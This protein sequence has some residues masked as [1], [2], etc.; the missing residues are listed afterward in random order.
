L[1]G[2]NN[3]KDIGPCCYRNQISSTSNLSFLSA[4]TTEGR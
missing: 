1:N 3:I 2:F 4:A